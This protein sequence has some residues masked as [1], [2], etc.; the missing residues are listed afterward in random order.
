MTS[1]HTPGPWEAKCGYVYTTATIDHKRIH[2]NSWSYNDKFICD[3]DDG[4]YHEYC[5]EEEQMANARLIAAAPDMLAAMEEA[6]TAFAVINISDGL[7]SQARGCL[8]RA[9]AAVNKAIAQATGKPYNFAEA[10]GVTK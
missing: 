9:W 1:K 10:N 4:E 2:D 8:R 3:L 5:N 7:S 6:D